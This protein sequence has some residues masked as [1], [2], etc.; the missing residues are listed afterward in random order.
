MGEVLQKAYQNFEEKQKQPPEV[1]CY[2][3]CSYKFRKIYRKTPCQ[4]LFFNKVAGL[5]HWHRCFLVIF[6]EFFKN[7]FFIEHVGF[8]KP[9]YRHF[10]FKKLHINLE[11]IFIDY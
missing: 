1:F 10:I 11:F 5:R 8:I 7:T 6:V 2:R 4:S 3:I 9:V